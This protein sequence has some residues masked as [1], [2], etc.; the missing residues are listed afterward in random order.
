MERE[1]IEEVLRR[2][3]DAGYKLVIRVPFPPPARIVVSVECCELER[4]EKR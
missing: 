4:I 2:L 1:L 3:E